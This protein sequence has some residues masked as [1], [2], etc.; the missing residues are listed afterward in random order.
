MRQSD[1][2]IASARPMSPTEATR[3]T[4]AANPGAVATLPA[5]ALSAGSAAPAGFS[6]VFR[7]VQTEVTDFLANGA[8]SLPD[9]P[10]SAEGQAWL[11]RSQLAAIEA[12]ANTGDQLRGQTPNQ[13]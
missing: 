10:L 11:G 3:P 8:P 6:T 13:K 2:F 7:Q 1:F 5:N 9:L 4:V 12:A